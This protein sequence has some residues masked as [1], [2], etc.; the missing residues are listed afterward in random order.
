MSKL[1]DKQLREAAAK[2]GLSLSEIKDEPRV[3]KFDLAFAI[4]SVVLGLAFLAFITGRMPDWVYE[5]AYYA[6]QR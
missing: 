3:D 4:A 2:G 1:T 6:S 5:F